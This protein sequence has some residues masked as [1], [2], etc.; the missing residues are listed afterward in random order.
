M[1]DGDIECRN[2]IS[3]DCYYERMNEGREEGLK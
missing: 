1:I 2:D 3:K